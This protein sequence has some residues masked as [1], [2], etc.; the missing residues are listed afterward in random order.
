[1]PKKE[2]RNARGSLTDFFL[3][4]I[5]GEKKTRRS[6]GGEGS[7]PGL[8]SIAQ[9]KKREREGKPW[10]FPTPGGPHYSY[11]PSGQTRA[12]EKRGEKRR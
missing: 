10:S 1:M 3:S 8:S 11:D 12:T 5:P 2:E 4:N 7:A 6:M 9:K